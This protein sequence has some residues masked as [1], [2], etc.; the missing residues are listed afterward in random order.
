MNATGALA[1]LRQDN[2][3][4][5]N[6]VD[7]SERL[8]VAADD[9]HMLAHLADQLPLG[10]TLSPPAGEVVV[11]LRLMLAAIFVIVAVEL[12]DLALPPFL[13]VRVAEMPAS[14]RADR[15]SG[16]NAPV[17][18]VPALIVIERSAA[19]SAGAAIVPGERTIALLAARRARALRALVLPRPASA[20]V[21][22]TI[23][24][25]A[26]VTRAIRLLAITLLIFAVPAHRPRTIALGPVAAITVAPPPAGAILIALLVVAL[27]LALPTGVAAAE[28][29][30][31]MFLL[32]AI[33]AAEPV[34]LLAAGLVP[35]A[36]RAAAEP[37]AAM[38]LMALVRRA[39][40]LTSAT[41]AAAV[42]LR[43]PLLRFPIAEPARNL[44]T[45][46]LKE[47]APA[48]LAALRSA[49][50]GL[51]SAPMIVRS[52]VPAA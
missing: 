24:L 30:G 28:P 46:A 32:L 39:L 41:T 3:I 15:R 7:L 36:I 16:T 9:V 2:A 45:S 48:T 17:G 25:A 27:L 35:V 21:V 50:T 23:L 44:V 51:A 20:R 29:T 8:T 13:V 31:A 37:P 14:R 38:L 40:P 4:A 33:L 47:A 6:L 34:A 42:V 18:F 49:A 11:E 26:H 12:V 43:T 5:L 52:A 19:R 10:L 22:V 1:A